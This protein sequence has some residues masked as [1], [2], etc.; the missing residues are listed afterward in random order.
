MT[1]GV[2]SFGRVTQVKEPAHLQLPR[3]IPIYRREKSC[4]VESGFTCFYKNSGHN[5]CLWGDFTYIT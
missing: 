5:S 1:D 4:R 2:Q 3:I